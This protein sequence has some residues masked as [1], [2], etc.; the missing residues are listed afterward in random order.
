M[1]GSMALAYPNRC[2]TDVIASG[3]SWTVAAPV[4]NML[5]PQI[6][7]VSRSSNALT[8][9]TKVNIDLGS[10]RT[11]RCFALVNHNLSSAAQW[12]VSLGTTSGGTDVYAGSWT[13]VWSLT[14][15]AGLS[16]LGIDDDQ[17]QS[18]GFAAIQF[19]ASYKTARHLTIE[20][21]DT[22]NPDGYV[23]WGRVFAAGAFIPRAAQIIGA[24]SRGWIDL[25][26]S[27]RAESGT[28]SSTARRRIRQEAITIEAMT[29]TEFDTVHEMQRH[30]GTVDEVFYVAHTS[31]AS[32]MQRYS[33]LAQ[34]EE[35]SAGEFPSYTGKIN[36]KFTECA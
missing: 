18:K 13:D 29:D 33:F 12:R 17:Y 6:T 36:L 27:A 8:A 9:S 35:L 7:L 1:W 31:N 11:L 2:T 28:K 14:L 24:I 10:A 3:G 22:T 19:L 21:D 5:D 32:A 20:V 16:S 4:T 30:L 26:T 15:E 25:S 34:M 23:Q